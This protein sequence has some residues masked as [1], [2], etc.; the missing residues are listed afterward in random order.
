M[1]VLARLGPAQPGFSA[2]KPVLAGDNAEGA[3]CQ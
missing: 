3:A 2:P 1:D